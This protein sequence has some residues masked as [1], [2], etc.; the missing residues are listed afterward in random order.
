MGGWEVNACRACL[1]GLP[2]ARLTLCCFPQLEMELKVL[3]AQ[4]GPAEQ[5]VLLSREEA[6]ELRYIPPARSPSHLPGTLSPPAPA[7]RSAPLHRRPTAGLP[8]F[9]R[10]AL[11]GVSVSPGLR[12]LGSCRSA[13]GPVCGQ[14][15]PRPLRPPGRQVCRSRFQGQLLAEQ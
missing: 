5:S 3:Q 4:A 10:L 11:A 9:C 15:S 13:P 7:L 6:S 14:Q 12:E 1:E 2:R 8:S